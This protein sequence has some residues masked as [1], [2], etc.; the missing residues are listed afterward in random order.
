VLQQLI[1]GNWKMNGL[2]AEALAL[3]GALRS[4]AAC[5][6]L[7][8]PPATVLAA[9]ADA[10][11]GSSVMVGGQDCHPDPSG[12][13]TGDVSAPMLRDAG[14]GWVILGHSERRQDHHETDQQVYAKV[15]AAH[16]AGLQT[17][18][19]VGETEQERTAGQANTVV[20]R[21]LAGSLPPDYTGVVAYEPI[22]AIGTGRTATEADVLEMHAAIRSD[23]VAR[24][25]PNGTA[26][27]I[28]YG[29]SVKP[30]NATALLALPEVGGALIG[31]ASLDAAAFLAIASS[32][33]SPPGR[34]P[35]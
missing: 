25:G 15:A 34:G 29:G 23:L 9:V 8:C 16:A 24:Q 32:A 12:A 21:Q 30:G 7:V 5:D 1:A 19:C 11:R 18:V 31:G 3:A 13:H 27:R 28:L 22:W 26:I 2:R 20:A 17:I 10:L 33:P 6:M 4:G 14:A 35:G